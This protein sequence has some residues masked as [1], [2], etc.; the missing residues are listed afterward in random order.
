MKRVEM[1]GIRCQDGSRLYGELTTWIIKPQYG[2]DPIVGFALNIGSK[3][4]K[5][6]TVNTKHPEYKGIE[7]AGIRFVSMV[8]KDKLDKDFADYEVLYHKEVQ[9]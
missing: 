7:D 8:L 3:D 4:L 2:T 6:S 5:C 9:Q 1:I